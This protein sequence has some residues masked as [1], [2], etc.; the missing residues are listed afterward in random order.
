MSLE[1]KVM[2]LMKSAMKTKDQA[3]LRTA[4]SIKSAILLAKTEKGAS[5]ELSEEQEFKILQKMA[6]Q[7]K[8][9]IDIFHKEGREDLATTEQEELAVIEEFLPTMMN[10]EEITAQVKQ[11]LASTGAASMQDMGKVMG[12]ANSVFAGK[13][14]MGLV[15]SIVKQELGA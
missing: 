14:D 11:I 15:S 2:E 9:S 7:R 12:Q 6:K 4:R 1:Q 3:K 10:E 5:S 8:D 13:A